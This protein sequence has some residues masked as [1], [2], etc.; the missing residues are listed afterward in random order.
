MAP[1][2]SVVVLFLSPRCLPA[3][4]FGLAPFFVF[5]TL[6]GGRGAF[7]SPSNTS[8]VVS[9]AIGAF[10]GCCLIAYSNCFVASR[11]RSAGVSCYDIIS[12][13]ALDL[14]RYISVLCSY[15]CTKTVSINEF[16]LI[17]AYVQYVRRN[18]LKRFPLTILKL[19]LQNK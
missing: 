8:R 15:I 9:S 18:I 16:I 4:R 6:L 10:F 13:F 14:K 19:K 12:I 11:I 2:L 7:L 5:W 17:P 1:R 3:F